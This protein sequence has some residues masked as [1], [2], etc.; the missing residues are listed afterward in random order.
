VSLDADSGTWASESEALSV[1]PELEERLERMETSAA[2][3]AAIA[4]LPPDQRAAIVMR[5]YLELSDE[6]MSERLDCAR[7]TVRWKLHAARRKL[8]GLLAG[9]AGSPQGS[10]YSGP[11][12]MADAPGDATLGPRPVAAFVKGG[13]AL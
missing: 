3:S 11:P 6:E 2:V 7:S 12:D 5:Y 9:W 4:Q 13:D 1:T 10:A 8:H